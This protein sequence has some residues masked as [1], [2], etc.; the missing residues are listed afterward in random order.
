MSDTL[1]EGFKE[2]GLRSIADKIHQRLSELPAEDKFSVGRWAWEL[3]QN[4]KDSNLDG[5]P[6]N[7]R[8][9]LDSN[10]LIFSHTGN[11]FTELDIRG[12][13]NVITSKEAIDGMPR[14]KT[15]KFG[16]GFLTTHLLSTIVD[17][18]ILLLENNGS[19]SSTNFTINRSA[20]ST[21]G[22]IPEIENTT[23]QAITNR[24]AISSPPTRP[25]WSSSL[26]T[27]LRWWNVRQST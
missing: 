25:S 18:E 13:I 22:L 3:L 19:Y 7:I 26:A 14:R 24:K 11:A 12:L 17:V 23:I 20:T 27:R 8:M 6:V 21:K 1:I 10:R 9:A 15:G 16:T 2:D 4:A 5:T